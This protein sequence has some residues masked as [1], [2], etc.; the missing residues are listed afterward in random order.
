MERRSWVMF[1]REKILISL[2]NV[3]NSVLQPTITFC[4]FLNHSS[5]STWKALK[6]RKNKTVTTFLQFLNIKIVII[7]TILQKRIQYIHM[8]HA[9][10]IICPIIFQIVKQLQY[11]FSHIVNNGITAAF[12]LGSKVCDY[13]SST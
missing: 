8:M 6:Y 7:F 9:D 13:A 2:Q 3:S 4:K 1:T 12:R 5:V 10:L 11:H